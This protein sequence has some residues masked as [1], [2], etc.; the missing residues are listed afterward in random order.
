MNAKLSL[1][2]ILMI[3]LGSV[4][5]GSYELGRFDERRGVDAPWVREAIAQDRTALVSATIS[6]D[7]KSRA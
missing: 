1:V 5:S 4:L 3:A 6:S 2:L 7:F